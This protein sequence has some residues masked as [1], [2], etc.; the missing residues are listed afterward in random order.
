MTKS[1]NSDRKIR[2]ILLTEGASTSA[3]E[4]ITALGLSGYKV[5]I[6]DPAS[7]CPGRFSRFVQRFHRCP[8]M[9]EDPSGYLHFMLDL[10]STSPID[11]LL[12]IHEQGLLFAKVR[13][14]LPQGVALASASFEN[15]R[16]ALSKAGFDALL[17]ELELPRPPTRYFSSAGQL[18]KLAPWP[19]VLKLPIGTASRGTWIV[20]DAVEFERAIAELG[21]VQAFD[22]V[23]LAQEFI[24]G[25]TGH[26]QAV[27]CNGRLVGI[28][29]YRQLARG[30]G[31]GPSRKESI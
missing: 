27:F 20:L 9:A 4:A 10:M 18:R 3:R 8:G 6:C 23:V 24:A 1:A 21:A 29:M 2:C 16:R 13:N 22:D 19:C 7:W 12:P 30:A 17:L 11:V 5:E 15:Y 25:N 14:Q 31:G 28:H 26:A